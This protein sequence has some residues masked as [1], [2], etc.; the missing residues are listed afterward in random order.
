[1]LTDESLY[2]A[3]PSGVEDSHL[4]QTLVD[5]PHQKYFLSAKACMGILRRAKEREKTLPDELR[6]ALES[7]ILSKSDPA[8]QGGQRHPYPTRQDRS[9]VNAQ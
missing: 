7:Q 4:S 9:I 8:D 6:T 1:M 3:L 2:P 5:D